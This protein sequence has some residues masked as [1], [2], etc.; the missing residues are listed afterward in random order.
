MFVCLWN[1][2]GFDLVTSPMSASRIAVTMFV[3]SFEPSLRMGSLHLALNLSQVHSTVGQLFE[4]G[5][6]LSL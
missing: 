6:R 5:N 4:P 3:H 1:V 2:S